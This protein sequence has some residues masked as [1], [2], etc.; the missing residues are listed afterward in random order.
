M[1]SVEHTLFG[2]WMFVNYCSPFVVHSPPPPPNSFSPTP[3][4]P[5]PP[6]TSHP[7]QNTTITVTVVPVNDNAPTLSSPTTPLTYDENNPGLIILPNISV[8]DIDN[9]ECNPTHLSAAQVTLETA[10][11]D[12]TSETLG[13]RNNSSCHLF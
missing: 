13:V 10:T 1:T 7:P 11:S 4:S 3:P 8:S 6:P 5:L 9:T 12:S 2:S